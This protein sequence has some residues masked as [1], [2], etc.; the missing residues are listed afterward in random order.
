MDMLSHTHSTEPFVPEGQPLSKRH[1]WFLGTALGLSLLSI[2]TT[3]ILLAQ[4]RTLD[5]KIQD[6]AATSGSSQEHKTLKT[7]VAN[8]SQTLQTQTTKLN[9]LSQGVRNST[10][11]VAKLEKDI[12]R[13]DTKVNTEGQVTQAT[14]NIGVIQPQEIGHGFW[15]KDLMAIP[16]QRGTRLV[17]NLVNTAAITQ[18][19]ITFSVS[20]DQ[21]P[22][23]M[24]TIPEIAGGSQTTFSINFPD[25]A[26][27]H[28][29]QGRID[30]V[31]SSLSVMNTQ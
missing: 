9:E 2:T 12:T 31:S 7:Q 27:G 16:H 3:G 24:L 26:A 21:S 28:A 30:Y 29:V 17:G 5:Q 13:L 4:V 23:R 1:R 19:D 20:I 14:V 25:V 11:S 10:Q 15:V 22:A 8:L 6:V 18:S